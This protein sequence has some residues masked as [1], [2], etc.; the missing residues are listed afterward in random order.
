MVTISNLVDTDTAE[1]VV[2]EMI[3]EQ[4]LPAKYQ[5]LITG[6]IN[7]ILR[8]MKKPAGEEKNREE[9]RQ[10]NSLSRMESMGRDSTVSNS[11]GQLSLSR[12]GSTAEI[13]GIYSDFDNF[14]ERGICF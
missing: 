3:H 14:P 11:E 1:E 8:E 6:E 13:G 9:V 12:K 7:R 4:V 2:N 10:W 5:H